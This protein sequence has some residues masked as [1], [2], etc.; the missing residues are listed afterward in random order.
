MTRCFKFIFS[1]PKRNA[2]GELFSATLFKNPIHMRQVNQII[3]AIL[4]IFEGVLKLWP[5]DKSKSEIFRFV[6]F[7]S[8][9]GA[10]YEFEK[11]YSN[12]GH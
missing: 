5:N 9:K 4:S 7:T 12:S 6:V 1:F 3:I 2:A 8:E 11:S 10:F